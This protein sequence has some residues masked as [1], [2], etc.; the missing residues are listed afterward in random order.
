MIKP[1]ICNSDIREIQKKLEKKGSIYMDESTLLREA[2]LSESQIQQACRRIFLAKFGNKVKFMQIDN[3]GKMSIILR[4]KKAREGT[5]E[6]APD[7]LLLGKNR[8]GMFVEFKKIGK[9]CEVEPREEQIE[10]HE[11]L[12]DCKF[13]V[14]V[15]N[16]TVYFEKVICVEFASLLM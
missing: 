13:P 15:V 9:P 4:K 2:T 11:F 6:G 1:L 10:T 8:T 14:H 16:N 7:V 5:V 12:R 3:G